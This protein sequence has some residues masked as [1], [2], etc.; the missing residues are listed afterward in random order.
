MK[1]VVKASSVRVSTLQGDRVYGSLD[2]VPAEL[3]ERIRTT[4]EG[5]RSETILIANQEAYD[6]VIRGVED[7]P[8][9]MQRFRPV[10]LNQRSS[11]PAVDAAEWRPLLIGGLATIVALWGLWLWAL[12]AGAS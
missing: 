4:L 7:L 11:K 9:E 12:S 8:E 3:R 2:D 5:P 1:W 6:R 10:L